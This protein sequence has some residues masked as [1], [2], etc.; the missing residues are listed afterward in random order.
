[1]LFEQQRECGLQNLCVH[2][3]QGCRSSAP[4]IMIVNNSPLLFLALVF[5]DS[6][7]KDPDSKAKD[8]ELASANDN[9]IGNAVF[10]PLFAA[11][12]GAMS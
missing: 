8:L 9:R 4:H 12:T 3:P 7:A 10:E 5:I 1:M 6:K 11:A 2:I